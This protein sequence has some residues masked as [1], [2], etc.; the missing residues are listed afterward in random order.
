MGKPAE[1]TLTDVI[2]DFT[3]QIW[4][5]QVMRATSEASVS[6]TCTYMLAS[7]SSRHTC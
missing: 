2:E 3:T 5:V 6:T 1:H 7:K 4:A